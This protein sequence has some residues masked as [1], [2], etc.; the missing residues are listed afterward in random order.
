MFDTVVGGGN[1][2]LDLFIVPSKRVFDENKARRAVES[3]M[4]IINQYWQAKDWQQINITM[5]TSLY[6]MVVYDNE[7]F[8]PR[9]V[10]DLKTVLIYS[11]E[12]DML[13]VFTAE[14]GG[15]VRFQPRVFSS[16]HLLNVDEKAPLPHKHREL[17]FEKLIGGWLYVD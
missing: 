14:G 8:D 10:T 5:K 7:W 9:L 1:R 4:S 12:I 6:Y 15:E 16:K 11:R 13:V 3:S 2:L 17:K